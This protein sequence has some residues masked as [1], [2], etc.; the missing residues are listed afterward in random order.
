[1]HDE[2]T[3]FHRGDEVLLSVMIID[4]HS[5]NCWMW[6]FQGL[7]IQVAKRKATAWY[8]QDLERLLQELGLIA[9]CRR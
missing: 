2:L 5:P 3:T 4:Q 8:A 1:M 9:C 7:Y 6:T